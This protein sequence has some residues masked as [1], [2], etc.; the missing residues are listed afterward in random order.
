MVWFVEFA[1]ELS[2]CST[3]VKS[4]LSNDLIKPV[5]LIVKLAFEYESFKHDSRSLAETTKEGSEITI[6]HLHS[7]N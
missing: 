4:F 5:G 1:D 2:S 7:I 6:M 3:A